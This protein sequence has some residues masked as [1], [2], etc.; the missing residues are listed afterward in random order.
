MRKQREID[1]TTEKMI[2]EYLA[3]GGKITMCVPSN[4]KVETF[5][6]KYSVAYRGRKVANLR[7]SGC[8]AKS[9]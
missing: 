3:K 5:R 8:Y 1:M 2:A 6:S 9:N 7:D 4:K